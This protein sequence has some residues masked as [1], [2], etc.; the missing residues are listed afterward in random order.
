VSESNAVLKL[1]RLANG[2]VSV[3]IWPWGGRAALKLSWLARAFATSDGM[4]VY[5]SSTLGRV[6]TLDKKAK[7]RLEVA[8]QRLTK[9]R[10]QLAGAKEQLDDQDEVDRLERE[11]QDVESQIEKLKQ[12]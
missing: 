4:D 11:V 9:L 7:K 2:A 10:Q 1:S 6:A 5:Q 8:R 12:S 3:T